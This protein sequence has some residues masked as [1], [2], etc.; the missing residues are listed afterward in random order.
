MVW[1]NL[2]LKYPHEISIMKSFVCP[3]EYQGKKANQ[4]DQKSRSVWISKLAEMK[5]LLEDSVKKQKGNSEE[6]KRIVEDIALA[7]VEMEA[8]TYWNFPEDEQLLGKIIKADIVL[9]NNLNSLANSAKSLNSQAGTPEEKNF[10]AKLE[11]FRKL[12]S[13]SRAVFLERAEIIRLK[14]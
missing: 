10:P 7:I 3:Y 6:I 5:P 14:K 11:N 2:E 13:D 8:L 4:T 9:C 12:L 1:Q